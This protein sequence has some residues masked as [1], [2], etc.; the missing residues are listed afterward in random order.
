MCHTTCK[1]EQ[2]KKKFIYWEHGTTFPGG[3][4][5]EPIVCPYCDAIY[6]YIMTSRLVSS[7]KIEN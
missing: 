4:E 6:G 2:C 5:K 7:K 3:Q 1:N